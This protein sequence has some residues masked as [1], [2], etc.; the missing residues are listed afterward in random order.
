MS[1]SVNFFRK[2]GLA[3]LAAVSVGATPLGASDDRA[4][5][6]TLRLLSQ[7]QYVDSIVSIFG[8]SVLSNVRFAPV[9]RVDGLLSAGART[10]GVTS[11]A[12]EPMFRS[13][14]DIALRVVD[15]EQRDRLIPCRPRSAERRDDDCA[16]RFLAQAARLIY[17]RDVEEVETRRLTKFAGDA[18]DRAEDFY[19]G[20]GAALAY[21]LS[22][23]DFL[24]VRESFEPDPQRPGSWRLDGASRASRLSFFLWNSG[25]DD[26][27]L[28]AAA[29]GELHDRRGIERQ[30]RRMLASD[31][32]QHGARAFFADMLVL[33]GFDLVA[34]DPIIYPA[35]THR[36]VGQAREQLLRTV[37]DHVVV[38]DLDYRDLFTTRKTFM[39]RD[40]AAI[41]Q[42]PVSVGPNQWVDYE[43]PEGGARGGVLTLAGFLAR[44][45][46]PGRTSPT[47][48]GRGLRETML[49]QRVPDPPPNVNFSL[50]ED[51]EHRFKTARARLDAHAT[52]PVCAACHRLT[53]PIGLVLE[54]FD[55]AGQYRETEEGELI[56]NSGWVG[57][58]AVK[59]ASALGEALR[60]DPAVPSCVVKRL[61]AFGVGRKLSEQ[62]AETISRLG[63]EFARKG[64]RY[65]E[66]LQTIATSEEFFSGETSMKALPRQ[67]VARVN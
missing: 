43:F 40:L 13:A 19:L 25:P 16:E 33:E 8:P 15:M 51:H 52:N 4:E 17:R 62:D 21:M 45:S 5:T 38:R 44:Y 35:F 53:D 22:S 65:R 30:V 29:A 32:V 59:G 27:L 9:P 64:Y 23:P 50:F 36:V 48:R 3:L 2:T 10:A 42:V 18:A 55:G 63:N 46:H 66:L 37:V 67:E 61:Y 1:S 58:T 28:R 31:R 24:Y 14:E 26:A 12:L 11:G 41:Y 39:S 60:L 57:R 6:S 34:K 49:C 47:N 54:N 56:D 20:I 7:S